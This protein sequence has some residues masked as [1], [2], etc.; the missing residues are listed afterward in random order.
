M[1]SFLS[2]DVDLVANDKDIHIRDYVN[3]ALE[4]DV[5]TEKPV[6]EDLDIKNL[7]RKDLMILF[8]TK[9][10]LA[11]SSNIKEIIKE[12]DRYFL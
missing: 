2:N 8:C 4:A 6:I 11:D 7:S 5:I 10:I 12:C 9:I 1:Y 3:H